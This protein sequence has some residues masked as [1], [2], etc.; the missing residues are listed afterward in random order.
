MDHQ[1]AQPAALR[2]G[3]CRDHGLNIRRSRGL[4]FLSTTLLAGTVTAFCGPIGF[5]GWPCPTSHGCS[6]A[7]AT[8][9]CSYRVPFFRGVGAAPLRPRFQIVYPAVNA[10]TALLESDCG[11]GGVAQQILYGMIRLHD[12]SIGYDERTLLREV[13]A[14]I[15][16]GSLT[17]LIGRNGTAN[18]RCCAP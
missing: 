6:S 7:T 15:P 8:T 12:F 3:V 9:A 18:R 14:A 13:N 11:V 16:K 4:L 5:I 1:A 10:I 2:R 17:A